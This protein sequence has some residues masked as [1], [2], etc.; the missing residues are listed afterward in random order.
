MPLELLNWKPKL[1]P[2]KATWQEIK[3]V[4]KEMVSE[5]NESR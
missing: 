2:I 3:E 5:D 4:L 1:P